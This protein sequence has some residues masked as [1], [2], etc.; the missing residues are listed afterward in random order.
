MEIN[1]GM[2]SKRMQSKRM[3]L[4]DKEKKMDWYDNVK[5]MSTFVSGWIS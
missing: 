2:L 1:E 3:N 4:A 5:F